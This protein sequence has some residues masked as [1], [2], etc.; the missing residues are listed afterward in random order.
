MRFGTLLLLLSAAAMH[1]AT[2]APVAAAKGP[3]NCKFFAPGDADCVY[4]WFPDL[5]DDVLWITFGR[6]QPQELQLLQEMAAGE[7]DRNKNKVELMKDLL[8]GLKQFKANNQRTKWGDGGK[9]ERVW[10]RESPRELELLKRIFPH[11]AQYRPQTRDTL[12]AA[13]KFWWTRNDNIEKMEQTS[14]HLFDMLAAQVRAEHPYWQRSQTPETKLLGICRDDNAQ[15]LKEVDALSKGALRADL[16]PKMFD[17]LH[18]LG[19]N[20]EHALKAIK[21]LQANKNDTGSLDAFLSAAIDNMTED[22]LSKWSEAVRHQTMTQAQEWITH[23][24]ALPFF[25]NTN[26]P[27]KM[28][29]L[30]DAQLWEQIAP[31]TGQ[32]G[33]PQELKDMVAATKDK[34]FGVGRP[35]LLTLP[36]LLPWYAPVMYAH[37]G[38][39][40]Y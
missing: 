7:P 14:A 4:S 32:D 38:D 23:L 18:K 9:A 21:W 2:A 19:K 8:S 36:V 33:F 35:L 6:Q 40:V 10:Q 20:P 3:P 27:E 31:W 13:L 5:P 16:E 22:G 17:M 24:I 15:L 12:Q 29:E 30:L 26:L 37:Q 34:S 1:A 25:T 39:K 28:G 11:E